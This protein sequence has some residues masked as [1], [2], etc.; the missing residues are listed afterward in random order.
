MQRGLAKPSV[1]HGK[2]FNNKHHTIFIGGQLEN[3]ANVLK[4]KTTKTKRQVGSVE[5][6]GV[7]GVNGRATF[8]M[9]VDTAN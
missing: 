2:S 9:A 5:V 8:P 4:M 1:K 6:A 3:A 7:V